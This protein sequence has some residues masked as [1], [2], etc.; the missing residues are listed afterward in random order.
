M[1]QSTF[2]PARGRA[3]GLGILALVA[4][5]GGC[6]PDGIGLQDFGT[7]VGRV[8]DQ[9]GNPLQGALVS[10]TGTTYTFTTD[11]TG[12][13]SIERVAVGEQTVTVHAAGYIGSA[14][15]DVI[16]QKDQTVQAGDLKLTAVTAPTH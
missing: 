11:K 13:F 10:A 9:N 8:A 3:I 5:I 1:K 14:T 15:A 2:L 6:N 12:A 16:V 4:L 7:I